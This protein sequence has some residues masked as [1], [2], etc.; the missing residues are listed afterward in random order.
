MRVLTYEMVREIEKMTEREIREL[1]SRLEGEKNIYERMGN[2]GQENEKDQKRMQLLQD[3]LNYIGEELS[4][5]N[6]SFG[7]G[8]RQ[9]HK[10]NG[11]GIIYDVSAGDKDTKNE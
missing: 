4:V 11:T 2:E 3:L 5:V 7:F 1:G 8:G 10:V 9:E 6:F